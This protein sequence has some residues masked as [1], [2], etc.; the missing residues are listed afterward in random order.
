MRASPAHLRRTGEAREALVYEHMG[1][2]NRHQFDTTLST[3][4][5]PRYEII[6]TGQVFDG[7]EEVAAYYRSSRTAFPDQRNKVVSLRHAEDAVF[8]EF[9]LMGTHLG[10]LYGLPPT[11]REFTCRM[12]A[13]FLFEGEQ[14]VCERI[15]FDSATIL[16]QLGLVPGPPLST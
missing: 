11:G 5:H 15:Y 4:G 8:V 16:S 1:T 14:L 3:F 13:L 9:D 10:E 7:A 2:E 12:V 6:A